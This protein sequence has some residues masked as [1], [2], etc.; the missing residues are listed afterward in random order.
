MTPRTARAAGRVCAAA[1]DARQQGQQ[2]QWR[3]RAGG[4]AGSALAQQ[5][6][7]PAPHASPDLA[8]ALDGDDDVSLDLAGALGDRDRHRR[9]ERRR[10]GQHAPGRRKEREGNMWGGHH[11]QVTKLR[12][13]QDVE[14]CGSNS[15][16]SDDLGCT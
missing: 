12:R 10:L 8:R 13:I 4:G 7:D 15:R 2:G 14:S 11:T 6:L 1:V 5:R 3:G 9:L 16:L